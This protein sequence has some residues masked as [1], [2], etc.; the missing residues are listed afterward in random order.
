[1]EE[2]ILLQLLQSLSIVFIAIVLLST[3][4]IIKILTAILGKAP[5]RNIKSIISLIVGILVSILYVCK[6]NTPIDTVLLSF[7][8]CTFGYDLL[9]KPIIKR[10]EKGL[11]GQN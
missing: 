8:T 1:M 5:N 3:Y 2:N 9:I 10:L 11:K 7:L 4:G 6:L